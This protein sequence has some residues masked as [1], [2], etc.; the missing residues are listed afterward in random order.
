M[1][2]H[3]AVSFILQTVDTDVLVLLISFA[4]N[5]PNDTNSTIYA[6]MHSTDNED[7]YCDVCEIAAKLVD[8]P[9]HALLI[10]YAFTGCDATS[11]IFGKDKCKCLNTW[12]S[13]ARKP[14]ITT[15]FTELTNKLEY[16]SNA[17][18]HV[19]EYY[20]VKLC[21]GNV[22]QSSLTAE[23]VSHFERGVHNDLRKIPLSPLG[24]REHITYNICLQAGYSWEE[25]IYNVVYKNAFIMRKAA[26]G[27]LRNM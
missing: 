14:E 19:L 20:L 21:S 17:A 15:V 16:V 24:L 1:R 10:F 2:F 13:D 11:S 25:C 5:I 12:K 23:Q 3:N 26:I 8:R 18:F 6:E 4:S 27:S 9:S 7:T 22:S